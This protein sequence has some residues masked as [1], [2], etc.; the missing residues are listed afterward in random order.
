MVHHER[1]VVTPAVVV[2]PVGRDRSLLNQVPVTLRSSTSP[3]E[4]E[5][6]TEPLRVAAK[7]TML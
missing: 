7:S 6:L 4:E 2:S 3:P 5:T 1:M